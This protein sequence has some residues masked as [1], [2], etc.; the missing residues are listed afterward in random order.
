MQFTI[1]INISS[2]NF[3]EDNDHFF[4]LS[5]CQENITTLYFLSQLCTYNYAKE[6]KEMQY[7]CIPYHEIKPCIAASLH[8]KWICLS[9]PQTFAMSMNILVVRVGRERGFYWHLLGRGTGWCK[10]SYN[11]RCA[12]QNKESPHPNCS[13][14]HCEKP[15]YVILHHHSL[16]SLLTPESSL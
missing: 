2:N 14:C 8:W 9:F 4:L 5:V 13:H 3:L 1:I 16:V 15:C 10:I 11:S 6:K 12:S 7:R